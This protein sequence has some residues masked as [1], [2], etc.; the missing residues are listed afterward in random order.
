VGVDLFHHQTAD[1]RSIRKALDYMVPYADPTRPWPGPQ[2]VTPKRE[3]FMELLR[4]G[5]NVYGDPIYEQTLEAHF[6]EPAAADLIQ[7]IYPRVSRPTLQSR[8]D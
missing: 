3:E 5:G 6:R 2:I 4:R 8:A 1:G 7:I